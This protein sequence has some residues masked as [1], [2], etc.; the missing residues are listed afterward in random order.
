MI[1][2]CK[3]AWVDQCIQVIGLIV[4]QEHDKKEKA[5]KQGGENVTVFVRFQTVCES[6]ESS[7]LLCSILLQMCTVVKC[8]KFYMLDFQKI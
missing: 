5:K 8:P 6:V 3:A 4:G 1:F 7:G 2:Y